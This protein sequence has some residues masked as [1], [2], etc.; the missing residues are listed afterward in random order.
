LS[1]EK[2]FT[3]MMRANTMLNM[4]RHTK[5]VGEADFEAAA[6]DGMAI[7]FSVPLS[8]IRPAPPE[9]EIHGFGGATESMN[10]ARCARRE[11]SR[12]TIP[13]Y[14]SYASSRW[15]YLIG[16]NHRARGESHANL[17]LLYCPET[18]TLEQNK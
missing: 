17:Q 9:I 15:V 14:T 18:L 11:G 3:V 8:D 16:P 10:V 4:P 13:T 5:H 6:Y 12:S 2:A 1:A 7:T